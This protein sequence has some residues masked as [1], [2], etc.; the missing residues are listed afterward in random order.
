MSDVPNF[1]NPG[2]EQE[3]IDKFDDILVTYK[4]FLDRVKEELLPGVKYTA[5][6]EHWLG[7][8]RHITDEAIYTTTNYFEKKYPEYKDERDSFVTRDTIKNAVADVLE[9][10]GLIKME[11]EDGTV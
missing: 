9:Q 11:N 6:G 3:Y 8:L 1:N 4:F 10:Y 2:H 5:L 7:T